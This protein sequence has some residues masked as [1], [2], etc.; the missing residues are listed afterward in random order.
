MTPRM[1]L[2]IK[3]LPLSTVELSDRLK[4]ELLENPLLEEMPLEDGQSSEPEQAGSE[5]T[6]PGEG[7]AQSVDSLDDSEIEYLYGG[8]LDDGY[9]ERLP[10]E[11]KERPSI[12]N[13][14]TTSTSLSDHLNW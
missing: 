10:K 1:Q 6:E 5:M 14:L 11:G 8:N 3:L 13:H 2:G 12:E 4:Q 7:D 9:R